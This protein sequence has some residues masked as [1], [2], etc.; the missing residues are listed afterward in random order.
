MERR[1][2]HRAQWWRDQ[3]TQFT[4]SGMSVTEWCR[5]QGIPRSSLYYWLEKMGDLSS[6]F[7]ED[8]YESKRDAPC[9]STAKSGNEKD[10]EE[11]FAELLPCKGENVHKSYDEETGPAAVICRQNLRIEIYQNIPEETI[12]QLVKAVLYA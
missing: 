1:Q 10:T 8:G 2:M 4:K 9:V 7:S 12:G 5:I 3:I 11:L 6:G